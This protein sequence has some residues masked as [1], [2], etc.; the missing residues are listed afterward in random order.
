MIEIFLKLLFRDKYF[1]YLKSKN[2]LLDFQ[3]LL[4]KVNEQIF[5]IGRVILRT[6]QLIKNTNSLKPTKDE[7]TLHFSILVIFFY[8]RG[9]DPVVI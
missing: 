8:L 9:I 2:K 5:S 3:L 1:A 6:L 4:I 7:K